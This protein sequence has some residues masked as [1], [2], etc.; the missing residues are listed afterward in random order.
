ML[1]VQKYGGTSLADEE[2]LF[3]AA[4]RIVRLA[5]QGAQI[6][7]VVSAQGDTTDEMITAATAVNSRGSVREMDAYL[8]CGEQMSAS[9]MAMAI[10]ALG[11]PAVSLTGVQAGI[12]TDDTYG[13]ARILSLKSDRIQQELDQGKVVVVAGFQGVAPNGDVT[14]L[15]RGGSDTTAVALAAFLHAQ[16]CQIFTDVDGVYDRDP[17]RYSGAIRFD[18]ISYDK[19]LRLIEYGAQVLHDRSVEFAREYNISI[20]VLS[21]FTGAPGTIVGPVQ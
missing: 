21:A 7:V 13:N 18:R 11:H 8:A 9:L 3:A 10:G 17:R 14:T 2:R 19:M 4:R 15:G 5:Q 6:V 1:I 16:V 12:A 20:E